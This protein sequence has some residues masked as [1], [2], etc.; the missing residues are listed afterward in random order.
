MIDPFSYT[1][2]R[3]YLNDWL[4]ASKSRKNFSLRQFA[5]RAGLGSPGYLKM[6][7]DAKRN[8]GEAGL[9]RFMHGIK[10]KG[11]ERL[12]FRNLVLWNQAATD[13]E[14]GRYEGRLALLRKCR[15]V[16]PRA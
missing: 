12:F 6:V 1:D 3:H 7:I 4:A 9:E 5:A 10:L 11:D 8:L 13:E 15:Q 14:R 16:R 2:Y